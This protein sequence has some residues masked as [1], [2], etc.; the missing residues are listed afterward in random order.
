VHFGD[1][2]L[3]DSYKSD[4]WTPWW[5]I[6]LGGCLLL[7]GLILIVGFFREGLEQTTPAGVSSPA[8]MEVRIVA[9]DT[10]ATQ[11]PT[12]IPCS[13]FLE[14]GTICYYKY[15]P[16]APA[17]CPPKLSSGYCVYDGSLPFLQP[18]PDLGVAVAPPDS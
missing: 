16:T 17:A 18:T 12:P 9:N 6:V 8:V 11:T 5:V 7:G 1:D 2:G 15:E 13:P 14:L 3:P 4:G 10:V